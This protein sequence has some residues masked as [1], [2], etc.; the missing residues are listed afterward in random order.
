MSPMWNPFNEGKKK[1]KPAI[2]KVKP[3]AGRKKGHGYLTPKKKQTRLLDEA[4]NHQKRP[5][6]KTGK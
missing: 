5:G 3:K 2:R 1:K 4:F 6:K